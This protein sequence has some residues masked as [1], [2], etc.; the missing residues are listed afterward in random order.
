MPLKAKI[1]SEFP[2]HYSET[3]AFPGHSLSATPKVMIVLKVKS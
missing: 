1:K 3:T 2:N